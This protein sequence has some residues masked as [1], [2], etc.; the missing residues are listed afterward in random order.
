MATHFVEL[1]KS[2]VDPLYD[3]AKSVKV[4]IIAQTRIS[5]RDSIMT[6]DVSRPGKVVVSE[7][8]IR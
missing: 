8:Q 1:F 7:I 2:W 6:S 5:D 3:V 4:E